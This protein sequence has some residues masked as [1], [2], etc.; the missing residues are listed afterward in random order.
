MLR[1]LLKPT[2]NYDENIWFYESHQF[3]VQRKDT[4]F[5]KF[6]NFIYLLQVLKISIKQT[7]VDRFM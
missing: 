4:L 2:L 6:N 5:S 1:I 3:Q 7:S